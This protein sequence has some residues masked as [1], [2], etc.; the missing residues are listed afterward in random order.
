VSI[1]LFEHNQKAYEAAVAML[2]E[3]GKAAVIHPTG[4]GKSFI[5]FKYCEDNPDKTVCWLSPSRYI[6]ETQIENLKKTG[7]DV[8]QNI[9]FFTYKKLMLM[10]EEEIGEIGALALISDEYHRLGAPMW[11]GSFRILRNKFPDI[12]MLGLSATNIRYLDNQRDMADELFDGNIASEITLGE[13]IVRGILPAPKYIMTVFSYQKD[14]EK[15]TKKINRTKNSDIRKKAEK[16]LEKLRRAI[17]NA[18]GLDEIFYKHMENRTG[19]YIVFTQ[20]ADAMK[21]CISHASEWFGKVDSKPHIY[22]V[23]TTEPETSKQFI[24]FV[25]DKDTSHLRL[26]FCI[27]ALNEGIHLD[28]IDGV[29]LFRPTISPI[30]YKQQIGRALSAGTNKTPVIFDI[31]N[32]IDN[33]YCVDSIKEEMRAAITYY[34]YFGEYANVVNERFEIIDM[35]EDCRKLFKELDETLTVSWDIMYERASHY[36]SENGNLSFPRECQKENSPLI[37]WLNTQRKIRAGKALGELTV[38][39]IKKLDAIGM[40]WENVNDVSWKRNFDAYKRYVKNGGDLLV[41]YNFVM[42]NG[43]EIGRWL[44][45]LRRYKKSGIRNNYF[46]VEREKALEEV[47]IIWDH[48][49]FMWERNYQAALSFYKREGNL[50]VPKG[51]IE[52]GVKLDY[53]LS[54]LRKKYRGYDKGRHGTITEI[55]I[56]RLNELGMRWQSQADLIWEEGFEHAKAY[57]EETGAADAPFIYVAPDGYKLGLF[58]SKC[59]EKFAKGKLSEERISRLNSINMVWSKSRKNDWDTCFE[60]VKKYFLEYGNL[61]IPPDYKVDGI[62]LNKW[63]NEQRQIMLGK[64]KGKSLTD[65]QTELLKS[66]SF[67]GETSREIHWKTML[68]AAEKFYNENGFD[69]KIPG[70]LIVDGTSLKTWVNNEQAILEGKLSNPRTREQIEKLK[71]IGILKNENQTDKKKCACKSVQ[72]EKSPGNLRELN[73]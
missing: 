64:R 52:N 14:L 37:T 67:T 46:T 59:R 28:D 1:E 47:G 3:T 53:W 16:Y 35:V 9:K 68:A 6:F 30:V 55:Q 13:A 22:A 45:M 18:D 2:A 31:V 49:D 61:N 69:A 24:E 71:K 32:N 56:Q 40:R 36:Y 50:E 44:C 63:L 11:N 12:P 17:E 66:I 42:E 72:P 19:K 10:S 43:V 41:P 70:D 20:R 23:R 8:P 58:L 25:N 21:E 65:E 60:H 62:W 73:M 5:G 57:F 27:D 4:T 48:V 51:C 38:E 7:A 26:L 54:D 34:N 33:L 39:R 29:I 15:Y